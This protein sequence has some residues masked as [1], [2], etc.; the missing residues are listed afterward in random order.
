MTTAVFGR[1]RTGRCITEDDIASLKELSQDRR[2]FGCS[3]DVL[4]VVD[5]VCSG[6]ADCELNVDDEILESLNPCN[7]Q[8]KSFL[9]ASY[10]CVTG[11]FEVFVRFS[12]L[13][14]SNE[15]SNCCRV[16]NGDMASINLRMI[17]FG[18]KANVAKQMA[19]EVSLRVGSVVL[20]PS[21]I[22][23]DLGVW[24]ESELNMHYNI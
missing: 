4:A 1:M 5:A 22:V 15:T 14:T 20:Q 10:T 16:L 17:W 8:L 19:D 24:L 3:V 2:Y 18:S 21:P 7:N 11:T 9:E 6:K 12:F 13:V 23:R